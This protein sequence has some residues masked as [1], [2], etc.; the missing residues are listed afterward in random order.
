MLILNHLKEHSR[1]I[2]STFLKYLNPCFIICISTR[3]CAWIWVFP[4]PLSLYDVVSC[5]VG[6]QLFCRKDWFRPKTAFLGWHKWLGNILSQ[7]HFVPVDI[8]S[9]FLPGDIVCHL[10]IS[11]TWAYFGHILSK[12]WRYIGHVLAITWSWPVFNKKTC[13]TICGTIKHHIRH[14]V[15]RIQLHTK[16]L[17]EYGGAA[18]R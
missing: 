18:F 10:V 11:W 6:S 7:R 4:V 3:I 9:H 13:K 14:K 5:V 1:N 15:N 17:S 12:S 2:W 16:A 8:L